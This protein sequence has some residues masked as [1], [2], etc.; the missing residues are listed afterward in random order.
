[1]N[2]HDNGGMV[3]IITDGGYHKIGMSTG[4]ARKR[5]KEIQNMNPRKLEVLYQ[6]HTPWAYDYE[7]LIHELFDKKRVRGEWF[8]L[9]PADIQTIKDIMNDKIYTRVGPSSFIKKQGGK[10]SHVRR[11]PNIYHYH[12]TQSPPKIET[13]A[14]T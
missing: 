14:S 4:D 12:E 6:Q 1:M 8:I 11:K 2:D 3:Y 7:R 5:L 13:G 10:P 9:E